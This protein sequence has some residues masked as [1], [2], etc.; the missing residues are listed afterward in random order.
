M[1]AELKLRKLGNSREL[2]TEELER[3]ISRRLK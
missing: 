3:Q 1:D 2:M